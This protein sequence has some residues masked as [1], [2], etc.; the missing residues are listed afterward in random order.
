[1]VF[2]DI[3]TS[4]LYALKETLHVSGTSPD[5]V[6]GVVSLIFWALMLVVSVKYLSFITRADNR[7]EGGIFALLALQ[8]S[9]NSPVRKMTV[10]IFVILA[11]AALLYG[12]GM[13]TPAISVLA[14]AEGFRT[15]A[16]S[17]QPYIPLLACVILAGLFWAQHKGTHA[18]GRLFGPVLLVWFII[19]GLLGAWH[20]AQNPDVLRA[21]NPAHGWRLLAQLPVRII[22]L[23][24]GSVVLAIT[25]VEALYADMGHFGRRAIAR[26]WYW[27]VL[28]GLVLNY[29]GQG[30]HALARPEDIT[31]PFF[32]LAPA[33]LPRLGLVLL[34]I[35]ATIIAS[36]ALISGTFSLTRQAIQLGFIPRLAVRH[37]SAEIEGQIYLPLVNR[38]LAVGA[39][40][41]VLGF[42]SSERLAG[43]YG[44]AV[45]GAMTM[46]TVAFYFVAR[47]RWRWS[48][49]AAGALCA[50]F[51]AID[52]CLFASNIP[53]VPNGGW[54]PLAT[55]L[56]I[57]LVMH[58]WKRGREITYD[59][60]YGQGLQGIEVAS[61][62]EGGSIH[63]VAGTAIFMASNPRG[64]PLAL[65]HHLKSNR[66]VQKT[67]VLLTIAAEPEPQVPDAERLTFEE[68]GHDV[69]RAVGRYGYMESP[70]VAALVERLRA[71]GVKIEPMTTTYYFNREMV[72]TGG[73]APLWE[74]QKSLYAFLSRF[75]RFFNILIYYSFFS[76]GFAL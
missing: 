8:R 26:A 20:V 11:G 73:D 61:L 18:I 56:A 75:P 2:G 67:L 47:R 9:D 66:C 37:T 7:G 30:A 10:G 29:F 44:I 54:L 46:T 68:L 42:G 5:A 71:G 27:V 55:G 74:W 19:L 31:N 49:P 15:V 48:R 17:I 16:P 1:V 34:S 6:Y 62:F 58:V 39:I 21:L 43:A 41:T 72:L 3:G 45:T 32:A 60:V 69:W 36:Q 22:A 33:G 13:I 70:D 14:A 59:R 65:M 4:P 57:L 50:F 28:P 76:R 40:A 53:K 38:L 24:L 12:E 25:G 63:R 51:L 35:A 23:V 52:L 64:T